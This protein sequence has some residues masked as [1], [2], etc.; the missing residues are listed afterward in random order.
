[1]KIMDKYELRNKIGTRIE[2]LRKERG[3]SIARLA[4]M[5]DITAA[6][7]NNIEKGRYSVGLEI[8]GRICEALE[9]SIE[10]EQWNSYYYDSNRNV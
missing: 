7:L 2:S 5:A 4:A 1:M 8:L 9:C 6:N 10:I 3:L